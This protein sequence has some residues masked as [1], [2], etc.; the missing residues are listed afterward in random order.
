M[1]TFKTVD[2]IG[3]ILLLLFSVALALSTEF[4]VLGSPVM[5]M[6]LVVGGWQ[7]VSVIVHLF[8]SRIYKI[9]L[10]K[11]YHGL[12]IFTLVIGIL[13]GFS[14]AVIPFL[15]GMLYWSPMLAILYLVCCYKETMKLS[16]SA[17][18]GEA[19]VKL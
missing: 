9:P 14:D 3:Q 15:F 11:W 16:P 17:T 8:F 18:A 2:Y 7:L 10:R 4:D 1:K 5:N 19:E 12:L 13:M 6:Y